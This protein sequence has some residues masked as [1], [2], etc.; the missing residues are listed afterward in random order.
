M[1]WRNLHIEELVLFA[2]I[3]KMFKSRR[4]GC[5]CYVPLAGEKHNDFDG[6]V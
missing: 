6:K 4:M 2:K 1:K 3:Y 5:S